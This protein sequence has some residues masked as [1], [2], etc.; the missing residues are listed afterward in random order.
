MQRFASKQAQSFQSQ[1]AMSHTETTSTGKAPRV[2]PHRTHTQ[3]TGELLA[4]G[5]KLARG[6]LATP[7]LTLL[8]LSP[9]A[10][11]NP[12]RRALHLLRRPFKAHYS[13]RRA[14]SASHT[15]RQATPPLQVHPTSCCRPA[16]AAA[17]AHEMLPSCPR[18]AHRLPTLL[19]F[20][21][22]CHGRYR[23]QWAAPGPPTDCLRTAD[24]STPFKD[25]WAVY[26][27]L[28]TPVSVVASP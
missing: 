10:G 9:T 5:F 18:A 15:P 14:H 4:L 3:L 25:A 17:T 19:L 12:H 20:L 2:S 24:V 6:L 26:T 1:L 21:R 28:T 11:L 7:L 8:C 27:K 13:W 22:R 23:L 16:A